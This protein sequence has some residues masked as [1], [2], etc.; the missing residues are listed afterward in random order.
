MDYVSAGFDPSPFWSLTFRLFDLHMR[1]AS[2]RIEREIETSNRHAYNTAALSGGA[3]AGKLPAYD[4][5]FRQ[6]MKVGAKQSAEVIEANLRALAIA[7]GA[8]SQSR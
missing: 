1:G 8:T 3:F 5:V 6:R 4:K 2:R 7:W